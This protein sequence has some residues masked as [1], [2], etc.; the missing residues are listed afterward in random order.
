MK[1]YT[2]AIC[3]YKLNKILKGK[4]KGKYKN[5]MLHLHFTGTWEDLENYLSNNRYTLLGYD[6]IEIK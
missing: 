6:Y 3:V 1:I 4:N 2:F 5:D